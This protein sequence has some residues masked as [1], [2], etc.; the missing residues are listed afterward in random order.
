M[1]GLG[2]G[3]DK[4]CIYTC[5]PAIGFWVF[6]FP[7]LELQLSYH[8]LRSSQEFSVSTVAKADETL[9]ISH[10]EVRTRRHSGDSVP[11]PAISDCRACSPRRACQEKMV[12]FDKGARVC[13]A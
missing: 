13:I 3:V 11:N 10:G 1:G 6:V 7:C 5:F 2:G 9:S 8:P 12:V 4:A